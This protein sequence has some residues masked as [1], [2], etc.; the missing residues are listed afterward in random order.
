MI[1]FIE[2]HESIVGAIVALSAGMVHL[3]WR[4]VKCD[5]RHADALKKI[6]K[7]QLALKTCPLEEKCG[8]YHADLSATDI[9]CTRRFPTP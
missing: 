5:E 6:N 9:L 2:V 7:L 8:Y 1:A 4:S 3:Y